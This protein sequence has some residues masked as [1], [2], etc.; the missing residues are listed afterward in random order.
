MDSNSDEL[1]AS[2]ESS[3]GGAPNV[4]PVTITTASI[5]NP[6]DNFEFFIMCL[7]VYF[8]KFH[9]LFT[10]KPLTTAGAALVGADG[11]GTGG[12]P[13]NDLAAIN[14]PIATITQPHTISIFISWLLSSLSLANLKNPPSRIHNMF[15]MKHL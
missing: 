3:G 10:A 1:P 13:A 12:G 15:V 8:W 2:G 14:N 9:P 4:V 5:I 11:V 7:F 6:T